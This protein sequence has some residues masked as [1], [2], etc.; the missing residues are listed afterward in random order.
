MVKKVCGQGRDW[1]GYVRQ[2]KAAPAY[3]SLH[4]A[5]FGEIVH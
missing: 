2:P 5:V 1:M 3:I 4:D